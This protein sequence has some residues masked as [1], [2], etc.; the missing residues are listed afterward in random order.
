MINPEEQQFK[1][2]D[3]V[4]CNKIPST[5]EEEDV[6]YIL[7]RIIE[8]KSE[9]HII[10]TKYDN[11]T[12]GSTFVCESKHL[13]NANN[14]NPFS[15]DEDDMIKLKHFNEPTVLYHLHGRYEKNI[16]F[17]K[18]GPLLIYVNPMEKEKNYENNT[19]NKINNINDIC[20]D[21]IEKYKYS[22]SSDD[23]KLN[24]YHVGMSALKYMNVLKKNQSIIITGESGSGK[25]KIFNS[26]LN[27]FSNERIFPLK[28]K[29]EIRNDDN[30]N[31]SEIL[32]HGNIIM[33]ALGN[34]KT[35]KNNN[36]NRYAKYC[37]LQMDKDK[38]KHIYMKKFLFDKERLINR[39]S[40]ENNFHIFYYILNGSSENFKKKY[41]L[42]NLEDYNIFKNDSIR[43]NSNDEQNFIQLLTSLNILFDD[44][45]KQIDF[46]F[47]ILSAI[48]L[49]GNIQMIKSPKKSLFRQNF[50][51]EFPSNYKQLQEQ[52]EFLDE[53]HI[54]DMSKKSSSS[55]SYDEGSSNLSNMDSSEYLDKNTYIFL[56]ASK[57]LGID[58]ETF[59]KY[60]TSGYLL[61]EIILMKGQNE[62]KVQKKIER[63]MKTCYEELLNWVIC[64]I[65]TK[66]NDNLINNKE[67][68]IIQNNEIFENEKSEKNDNYINI[69]DIIYF[70]NLKENSLEQFLINT[71][72]E[73]ILK[74]YTDF[75]YKKRENIYKQ[76]G[77]ELSCDSIYID[78]EQLYK[79]LISKEGSLFS[80]LENI[81]TKKSFD[82][83]NLCSTIVNRFIKNPYIKANSLE[84]NKAFIIIHSYSQISYK[85][86]HFIEKN[87]DILTRGFIEMIKKSDNKYMQQ[88]CSSYDYDTNGK[89]MEENKRFSVHTNFK[90]FKKE[91]DPNNQM[92][93]TL[94]RNNLLELTNSIEKSFCHF[95][96]CINTCRKKINTEMVPHF[97]KKLVLSQ[98]TNFHMMI[99]ADQ[100][101]DEYFPHMFSFFEFVQIFKCLKNYKKI[102]H[103]GDDIHVHENV[104]NMENMYH[105]NNPFDNVESNDNKTVCE[106]ILGYMKI[107]EKNWTIGKNM[108]FLN[109]KSMNILVDSVYYMWLNSLENESGKEELCDLK[110]MMKENDK[111]E[112]YEKRELEYI[113]L[114]YE[115]VEIQ[116]ENDQSYL[117]CDNKNVDTIKE[118]EVEIKIGSYNTELNNKMVDHDIVDN[119]YD[120]DDN[121][122]RKSSTNMSYDDNQN[123]E[124]GLL[125]V[126]LKK[127]DNT[128]LSDMEEEYVNVNVN[129]NDEEEKMRRMSKEK[130]RKGSKVKRK[131]SLLRLS[132]SL[133]NSF[134][135]M[136]KSKLNEEEKVGEKVEEKVGVKVDEKIGVKVEEKVGVKVEE[137]VGE[138]VSENVGENVD[139]KVCEEKDDGYGVMNFFNNINFYKKGLKELNNAIKNFNPINGKLKKDKFFN[140]GIQNF[141]N[142]K[143]NF[144]L[145]S[146]RGSDAS[147]KG[148]EN[149]DEQENK[150][151]EDNI[152]V[153]DNKGEEDN[154]D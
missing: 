62:M 45:K 80:L 113:N 115:N 105:T 8:K 149:K 34:A 107:G 9:D 148:E 23:I 151:E 125:K 30:I 39:R 6:L 16:F 88:F 32:K 54:W 79:I 116:M 98:V 133:R 24:E 55:S 97:D 70:E 121:V 89:I 7:C 59:L 65:T 33:E 118:M 110:E 50:I 4:W 12:N 48:L 127:G 5:C 22:H 140:M 18:M 81:C 61:N 41:F 66:Y 17:T 131:S 101:K 19:L 71:T 104:N 49:L 14:N 28:K 109:E 43:D 35:S 96:M 3:L 152:D 44:D 99:E 67:K 93:V 94:L 64:K 84:V 83:S 130:D 11:E 26:L 31:I 141:Y 135:K 153:K 142:K 138:N 103:E 37:I 120:R 38:I 150:N 77:L 25:S 154:I 72:N 122:H 51:C 1:E 74:V 124:G 92:A 86:E 46:F 129:V 137:N 52:L 10:L 60:F 132:T 87:V 95:I 143:K 36:C 21:V 112:K 58:A 53:S 78:N 20:N 27:F 2:G 47:S 91:Y 106:Q 69:L 102:N 82:K 144:F 114:D 145:D 63:F 85:T 76:E 128:S 90:L 108:I 73:F 40:D 68:E 123:M 134:Q 15:L 147:K 111:G 42:K 56:V 75:Y 13:Y 100:F 126:N 136:K 119:K 57:L 29:F 117:N 139:E 146:K